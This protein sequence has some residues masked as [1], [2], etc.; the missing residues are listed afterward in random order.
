M[1]DAMRIKL[2]DE[3]KA[4][5]VSE[6]RSLYLDEFDEELSDFQADQIVAFFVRIMGPTVYNQAIQDARGF[7]LEKLEDLDV[8]FYESEQV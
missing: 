4:A 2:S 7:M 5:I 3:R 8:E 6:L 1:A